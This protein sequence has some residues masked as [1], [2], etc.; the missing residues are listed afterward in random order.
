MPSKVRM[1][2]SAGRGWHLAGMAE[3]LGTGLPTQVRRFDPGCPLV[4]RGWC[5]H[6]LGIELPGQYSYNER[7]H[8]AVEFV[9]K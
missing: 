3:W 9:V 4:M 1:F 8:N 5:K 2:Y 7:Q 6:F